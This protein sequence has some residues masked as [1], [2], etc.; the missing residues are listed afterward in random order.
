MFNTV[1]GAWNWGQNVHNAQ[2]RF[3]VTVQR[4][5]GGNIEDES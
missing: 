5:T 1:Q 2:D 4:F 3:T